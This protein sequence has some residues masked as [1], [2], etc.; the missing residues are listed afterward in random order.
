MRAA[1]RRRRASASGPWPRPA[2][3]TAARVSSSSARRSISARLDLHACRSRSWR[4]RGCRRPAPSS[5]RRR[6]GPA[7]TLSRSAGSRRRSRSITWVMPRMPFSGVRISWLVV[8]RNSVLRRQRLLQRA[9]WPTSSLPLATRTSLRLRR[10]DRKPT[11][12]RTATSTAP[13]S[14]HADDQ[15][16]RAAPAGCRAPAGPA[17]SWAIREVWLAK[18]NCAD[19]S[20]ALVEAARSRASSSSRLNAF[21]CASAR[22]VSPSCRIGRRRRS[23]GS[24]ARPGSWSSRSTP[25]KVRSSRLAAACASAALQLQ[26]RRARPTPTGASRAP[27]ASRSAERLGLGQMPLGGVQAGPGRP[28]PRPGWSGCGP[29]AA[30]S[31]SPARCASAFSNSA[32]ASGSLLLGLVGAADVVVRGQHQH[33]SRPGRPRRPGRSTA[34]L[35]RSRGRPGRSSRCSAARWPGCAARRPCRRSGRRSGSPAAPAAPCPGWPARRP[36]PSRRSPCSLVSGA[37]RPPPPA[38]SRMTG[39]A[40]SSAVQAHQRLALQPLGGGDVFGAVRRRRLRPGQRE[41]AWPQRHLRIGHHGGLGGVDAARRRLLAAAGR[42]GGGQRSRRRRRQ[43]G[44]RGARD[45][46][47]VARSHEPATIPTLRERLKPGPALK[48]ALR[49]VRSQRRLERDAV[50]G[51]G[52]VAVASAVPRVVGSRRGRRRPRRAAPIDGRVEGLGRPGGAARRRRGSGS[53][54][55]SRRSRGRPPAPC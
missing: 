23:R 16:A 39:A 40:S 52:D 19:I 38:P 12:S 47:Q 48:P 7:P 50:A 35:S 49:G 18:S 51:A 10:I 3:P 53:R 55:R 6:R 13:A 37:R 4:R 54:G 43:D 33:R 2:R 32:T 46:C 17:F 20:A 34:A 26:L 25:A 22:A 1:R 8:A 11:S 45:A 30:G 27:T 42:R 28:R 36:R 31:P 14:R 5:S 44:G 9:C 41:R 29:R 21:R 24:R 15:V